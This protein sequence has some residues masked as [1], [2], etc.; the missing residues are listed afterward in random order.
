MATNIVK[1]K[2]GGSITPKKSKVQANTCILPRLSSYSVAENQT[3]LNIIGE[4]ERILRD[5]LQ[6]NP[7]TNLTATITLTNGETGESVAINGTCVN[8]S[9]TQY[10]N[11]IDIVPNTAK[12]QSGLWFKE[13]Y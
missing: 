2:N 8:S 3:Q 5:F 7:K 13:C 10:K 12:L 11:L 1:P 9:Q 4:N 6:K